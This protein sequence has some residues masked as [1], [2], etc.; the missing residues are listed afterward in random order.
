MP[1]ILCSQKSSSP[2]G[3][4]Q[5]TRV[6]NKPI[7]TMSLTKTPQLQ[8]APTKNMNGLCLYLFMSPP[9][10]HPK[11][12]PYLFPN[13]MS[14]FHGKFLLGD[15]LYVVANISSTSSSASRSKF[16]SIYFKYMTNILQAIQE[17]IVSNNFLKLVESKNHQQIL[18]C[19]RSYPSFPINHRCFVEWELCKSCENIV[20]SLGNL[21]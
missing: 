3:L 16:H 9:T 4:K 17:G 13:S 2:Q 19:S 1:Q 14:P 10:K 21:C 11:G 5:Y 12:G 20:F 7:T 8:V 18:I 15:F 6:T